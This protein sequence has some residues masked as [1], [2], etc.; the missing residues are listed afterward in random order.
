MFEDE[1][2]EVRGGLE[3]VAPASTVLTHYPAAIRATDPILHRMTLLFSVGGG[4]GGSA[5]GKAAMQR[6]IKEILSAVV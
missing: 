3:Q 6:G 1:G 5:A 4:G 2:P